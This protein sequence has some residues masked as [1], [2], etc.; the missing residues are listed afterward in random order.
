MSSSEIIYLLEHTKLPLSP[1]VKQELSS[2]RM[3]LVYGLCVRWAMDNDTT[4]EQAVRLIL[5]AR[6]LHEL[7]EQLGWEWDPPEP[8]KPSFLHYL[9]C[10]SEME[11]V[12]Q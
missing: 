5:L 2:F 10:K 1:S 3:M 9:A 11:E 12:T 7:A 8:E 4:S 6:A